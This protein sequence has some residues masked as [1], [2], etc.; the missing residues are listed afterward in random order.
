MGRQQCRAG[1]QRAPARRQ[2]LVNRDGRCAG[3][4]DAQCNGQRNE[5]AAVWRSTATTA[6]ITATWADAVEVDSFALGGANLT[7]DAAITIRLFALADDTEPVLTVDAAPD[8]FGAAQ[9][10]F[11]ATSVE[12]VE[13]E[14][15][16]AD[17]SAGYIEVSRLCVG[18]RREMAYNP[19]YGAALGYSDR[20]KSSRAESG[21]VRTDYQSGSRTL[22]IDF[23]VLEQPDAEFMLGLI[24]RDKSS[25]LFVSLFPDSSGWKRAAHSFFAVIADGAKLGYPMIGMWATGVVLEEMW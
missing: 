11:S 23:D 12:R 25:A 18:R 5:K 14:I 15:S 10:W 16:D 22:A 2:E 17:N 1:L 4:P 21:D 9:A 13:V 7:A 8:G 20:S 6:T 19:K 24:M 3:R